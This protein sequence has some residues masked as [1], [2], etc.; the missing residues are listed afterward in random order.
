MVGPP[1]RKVIVAQ[2]DCTKKAHDP[3]R[4]PFSL[5][6]TDAIVLRPF[7]GAGNPLGGFEEGFCIQGSWLS[8]PAHKAIHTLQRLLDILR[9]GSIGTAYMAFATRTKGTAGYDC[10]T[11]FQK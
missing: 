11:F 8:M 7:L 9:T 1:S 2:S 10:D 4:A 6:L 5:V 3:R